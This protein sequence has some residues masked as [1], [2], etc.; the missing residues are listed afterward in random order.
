MISLPFKS[1]LVIAHEA[2]SLSFFMTSYGTWLE[3]V[4]S[5]RVALV[6]K[7]SQER[8]AHTSLSAAQQLY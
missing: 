1:A 4:L 5:Q 7:S 3:S 8:V 6:I 2:L